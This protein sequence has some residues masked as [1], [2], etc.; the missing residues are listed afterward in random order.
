MTSKGTERIAFGRGSLS[1][2]IYRY[3]VRDTTEEFRH[4]KFVIIQ[5]DIKETLYK[6]LVARRLTNTNLKEALS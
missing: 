1:N 6:I 2:F 5:V 3:S 4:H